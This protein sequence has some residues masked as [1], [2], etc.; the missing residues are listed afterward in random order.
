MSTSGYPEA[1]PASDVAFEVERFEWTAVDRLE[2]R[3]RW[4]NVRGRRF[5]RP[6]LNIDAARGRRRLIALLDH[7]PWAAADGHP[8]VAAFAWDG[9]RSDVGPAVLEV[10]PIA[11]IRPP[12]ARA[13]L[14]RSAAAAS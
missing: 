10:V 9:A 1:P 5:M 13:A 11:T 7:K 2:V 8:W 12:A 4:S 14:R 3:G 6:S